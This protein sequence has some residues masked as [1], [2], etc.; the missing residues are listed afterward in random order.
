MLVSSVQHLRDVVAKLAAQDAVGLD[1]ETTGLQPAEGALICVV[2]LYHPNVG[3]FVVPWRLHG[4]VTNLPEDTVK[5]LQP[6]VDECTLVGHNIG[7]FDLNF[8]RNEGVNVRK[9][10]LWD[11]LFGALLWNDSLYGYGLRALHINQLNNPE[12]AEYKFP[13]T[14]VYA[15]PPDTL[16]GRAATDASLAWDLQE[17][18]EPRILAKGKPYPY[19]LKREMRWARFIA[20]LGWRG[21]ALDEEL[22]E[23]YIQHARKR[24]H[25]IEQEMWTRWRPGF[26]LASPAQ[27]ARFLEGHHG[28]HL[29]HHAPTKKGKPG[30]PITED[31][32]IK[33]AAEG[34]KR[35][36]ADVQLILEYRA[37]MKALDTWLEPYLRAAH[38]GNGRVRGH[39][40]I[41]ARSG[42]GTESGQTRTL[43]L[44]CS[45]PNL[46]GVPV[47][48]ESINSWTYHMR[49]VFIGEGDNELVGY[50]QSQA[51]VRFAAHYA[52]E[53][54]MLEELSRPDGDI[55]QMVADS[56][57]LDRYVAKRI[58]LG[59][60][61][62]IG[63]ALLAE[64]LTRETLKTV[65]EEEA[66][67]WLR[68][69][70]T[71]YPLLA[72]V[73]RRAENLIQKR[74]W[75]RLWNGRLVHFNKDRD[76]PYKAFNL[77]VQTG[78]AELLKDAIFGTLDFFSDHGMASK[79]VH[80]VYDEVLT[81][82][83]PEE[84]EYMN[85][86]ARRMTEI[87]NWRCPLVV[88]PW[89]RKRWGSKLLKEVKTGD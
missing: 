4:M 73:N 78:V 20:D 67:R 30:A 72:A 53:R 33:M 80:C 25:Q 47:A 51:E 42:K 1:I 85:D 13:L 19:L 32:V 83:P 68:R 76:V 36:E 82:T 27:V 16:V 89:H 54:D 59:T 58:N 57:R 87:G 74:G 55:H 71:R 41:Q 56:L 44:R 24:A 75:L 14:D 52:R 61:Y 46:Q 22:T 17:F 45:Q 7:P 12:A 79:V 88:E 23:K 65:P 60:I 70:R 81:E 35:A 26:K 64:V 21:L 10:R 18:L 31:W 28:L 15:V 40:G 43:R 34:N 38:R 66:Q 50:D 9:A 29:P 63:G 86:V 69:Y 11:T 6:L 84:I 62:S 8:L 39:W 37:H 5:M 2:S 77:L 3:V 49:S 48:D